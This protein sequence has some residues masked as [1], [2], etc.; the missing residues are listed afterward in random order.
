MVGNTRGGVKQAAPTPASRGEHVGQAALV[1]GAVAFACAVFPLT[2][3]AAWVAA[4][5]AV[6]LALVSLNAGRGRKRF[7]AAALLLG[8]FAFAY[9]F[10]MMIWG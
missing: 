1:L 6:V 7:A 10:A 4:L 5:P 2:R 9:S 8:W 3:E